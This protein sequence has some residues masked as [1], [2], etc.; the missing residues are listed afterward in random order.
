[1]GNTECDN[2]AIILWKE[3]AEMWTPQTT[4]MNYVFM[5]Y[6]ILIFK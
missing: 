3:H 5:A 1:M 6:I 4:N 2:K